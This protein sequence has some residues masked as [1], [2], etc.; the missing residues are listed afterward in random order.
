MGSVEIIPDPYPTIRSPA[1][2]TAPAQRPGASLAFGRLVSRVEPEYPEAAVQRHL[3]GLV[4]LRVMIAPNGSIEKVEVTE[5]QPLLADAAQRAVQQW[6]YE[7]TRLGGQPVEAE[8][9]ITIA[10]RL[11]NRVAPSN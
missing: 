11:M 1:G 7:P 4:K 6:R 3:A 5:G 9:N 2:S 8:E 10:F